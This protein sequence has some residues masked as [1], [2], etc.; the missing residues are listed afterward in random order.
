MVFGEPDLELRTLP[1]GKLQAAGRAGPHSAR[2]RELL[3]RVS[4][5]AVVKASV[6]HLGAVPEPVAVGSAAKGSNRA[7]PFLP[8]PPCEREG[9]LPPCRCSPP[10]CPPNEARAV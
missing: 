1:G 9:R 3:Q 4:Y 7:S 8:G 2:R 5:P 10:F 6:I